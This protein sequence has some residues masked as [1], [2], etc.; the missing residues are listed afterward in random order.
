MSERLQDQV[1]QVLVHFGRTLR[2][3]ASRVARC[4]GGAVLTGVHSGPVV[5]ELQRSGLPL[6]MQDDGSAADE[7]EASLMSPEQRWLLAQQGRVTAYTNPVSYVPSRHLNGGANAAEK[8]LADGI[9]H[10]NRFTRLVEQDDAHAETLSLFALHHHWVSRDADILGR[11]L[12]YVDAPVGI[13]L[14]HSNDPL[15]TPEAIEGL[16]KVIDALSLVALLRSDLAALGA[17]AHGAL[18][19]SIGIG[20]G[21]RHFAAP[22]QTGHADP[23]DSSPRVLVPALLSFWKATRIASAGAD[24]LL[25]CNCPVCDGAPLARFADQTLQTEAAEHSVVCWSELAARLRAVD[26]AHR[27]YWWIRNVV[28]ALEGHAELEE[29]VGLPEPPSKQLIAWCEVAGV[30]VPVL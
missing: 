16:L 28:A 8:V 29:R 3:N 9:A 27:A 5:Q 19:A 6:L 2:R 17:L 20:T 21:T 18:F 12:A 13:M 23:N 15:Q 22:G 30:P 7:V 11:R 24:P 10:A 4:A 25:I 1:D 14:W 26:A